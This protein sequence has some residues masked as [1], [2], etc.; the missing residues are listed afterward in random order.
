MRHL[1]DIEKF[2]R[3][4]K[5]NIKTDKQMD[6]LTLDGSYEVMDETLRMKSS[7][8]KS[9][10]KSI[11]MGLAAAAIIILVIG[12]LVFH[13]EPEDIVDIPKVPVV[14][15][16]TEDMMSLLSINLAYNRGGLDEVEKQYEKAIKKMGPRPE[17]I[18]ITELLAESNGT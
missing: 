17:Q 11:I 13:S 18:T 9:L 15:Q 1:E 12:L 5:A 16:S 10:R 14:T 3:L 2:V 8:Y 6:K 4:G 7:G